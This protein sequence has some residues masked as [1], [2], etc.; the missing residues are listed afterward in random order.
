MRNKYAWRTAG[1]AVAG[2]GLL[3]ATFPTTLRAWSRASHGDLAATAARHAPAFERYASAHG[4]VSAVVQGVQD[5][6]NESEKVFTADLERSNPDVRML[7]GDDPTKV[8]HTSPILAYHLPDDTRM[9]NALECLKIASRL[10]MAAKSE[11]DHRVAMRIFADGLHLVQD[12]FAHLNAPGRGNTKFSHGVSN[13]IDADGDGTPETPAGKVVDNVYWDCHSDFG[14]DL[15]PT[16]LRVINYFYSPFWHK[17][18][19]K[20]QS[21][22]YQ[23]ALHAGSEYMECYLAGDG[24]ARFAKA[25]TDGYVTHEGSRIY[26]DLITHIAVD[27]AESRCQLSGTWRSVAVPGCFMDDCALA[28]VAAATTA[29]T[30]TI[31]APLTARYEVYLRWPAHSELTSRAGVTV[32]HGAESKQQSVNQRLNPNRWNSLGRFAL[33]KDESLAVTL[34][35]ASG[36]TIAA[37][38]VLLVRLPE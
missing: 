35:A 31:S 32:R 4:L 34:T 12:Y 26:L 6:D 22:R 37:D 11:E 5:A 24:T 7:R 30:W 20:E 10:R 21:W 38:A 16:H 27:N 18:P 14:N 17:Y 3:L 33:T 29:A 19:A 36:E 28:T 25:L 9:H 8:Q 13:L 23:A 1:L 2:A 15:V